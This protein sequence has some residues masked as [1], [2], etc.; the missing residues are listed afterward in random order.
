VGSRVV[1]SKHV[2]LMVRPKVRSTVVSVRPMVRQ[3]VV[4]SRVVGSSQG[5]LRDVVWI[6]KSRVSCQMMSMSV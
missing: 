6:V 3:I 5:T 2:R 4:R 1:I